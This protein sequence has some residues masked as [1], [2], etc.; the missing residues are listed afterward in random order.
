MKD[1][2]PKIAKARLHTVGKT[3]EDIKKELKG[4]GFTCNQMKAMV[5]SN[6][7]FDGLIIYVSMWNWDNHENW[8]LHNW[9]DKDDKKIMLALYEAEQFHPQP[10]YKNDFEQFKKDWEAG[11]YEPGCTYT[12]PLEAVEVLEVIQEEIDNVD[13]EKIQKEIKKAEEIR[14]EKEAQKKRRRRLRQKRG[15]R[16]KKR[17]Y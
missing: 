14:R 15:S 11:E 6:N 10:K 16:Y 5:R 4:Q 17:F 8:H 3:Y 9:E 13:H 7:Y 1:Y 2:Q 12:F